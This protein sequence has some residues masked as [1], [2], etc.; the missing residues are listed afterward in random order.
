MHVRRG[1][2]VTLKNAGEFHG[3]CSVEYYHAALKSIDA[4][5]GAEIFMFSDDIEWC[6]QNL[7]FDLPVTYVNNAFHPV[8]DMYLMSLCSHNIIANSSFSWWA[9]WLNTNPEKKVIAPE[10]WFTG[11]KTQSL[12]LLLAGWIV[13]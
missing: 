12:D 8:W 9:A 7:K 11:K 2:Y 6:R 5:E 3:L 4:K 1:D 13:K 10:Y